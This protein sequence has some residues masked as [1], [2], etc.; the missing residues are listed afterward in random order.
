MPFHGLFLPAR[1]YYEFHQTRPHGRPEVA[2]YDA[3]ILAQMQ[4]E[5]DRLRGRPVLL[6]EWQK[7]EAELS[8][9]KELLR[10]CADAMR[11][12]ADSMATEECTLPEV[13][14]PRQLAKNVDALL[15]DKP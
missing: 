11:D 13:V 8:A 12:L 7:M 6:S 15:Q 3:A 2:V 1:A 5:I 14:V 4:A 10:K 9:A